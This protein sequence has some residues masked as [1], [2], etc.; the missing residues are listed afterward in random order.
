MVSLMRQVTNQMLVVDDICECHS[1]RQFSFV[2]DHCD[3]LH[4]AVVAISESRFSQCLKFCALL[5]DLCEDFHEC[6]ASLRVFVI[7][8]AWPKK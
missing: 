4:Q 6:G 5:Q 2:P 7:A 1:Y 3:K 8:Q